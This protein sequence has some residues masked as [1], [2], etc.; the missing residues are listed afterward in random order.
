LTSSFCSPSSISVLLLLVLF[1][2]DIFLCSSKLDKDLVNLVLGFRN[3]LNELNEL[4]EIKYSF[5]FD[6]CFLD[7][8]CSCTPNVLDVEVLIIFSY[9]HSSKGITSSFW[10]YSPQS[11]VKSGSSS[12]CCELFKFSC[13]SMS[14]MSKSNTCWCCWTNNLDAFTLNS[15]LSLLDFWVV[16]ELSRDLLWLEAS[17][18]FKQFCFGFCLLL[19]LLMLDWFVFM[20][21]KHIVETLTIK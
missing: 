2:T 14:N 11:N 12:N 7:F 10:A 15:I 20:L 16:S 3:E 21:V 8:C 6:L 18:N 4:N 19:L 17:W 5:W 9:S 13:S 1:A